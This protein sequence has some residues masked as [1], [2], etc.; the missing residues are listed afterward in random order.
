MLITSWGMYI[1]SAISCIAYCAPRL[2]R[3]ALTLFFFTGR[4][5]YI[6]T[7]SSMLQAVHGIVLPS[8]LCILVVALCP[9]VQ[10]RIVQVLLFHTCWQL[11]ACTSYDL[12]CLS[13]VGHTAGDVEGVVRCVCEVCVSLIW[14]VGR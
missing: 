10:I 1:K 6:V 8:M 11:V 4:G 2:F 9:R 13:A 7:A 14:V 5:V 12:A 3:S